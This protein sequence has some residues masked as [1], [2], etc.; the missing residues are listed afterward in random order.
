MKEAI[1]LIQTTVIDSVATIAAN[2]GIQYDSKQMADKLIATAREWYPKIL[3]ESKKDAE[4]ADLFGNLNR[5]KID[6]LVN[7]AFNVA[8]KHGCVQYA[9][10]L[11][12]I[13]DTA[14]VS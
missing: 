5:G 3:D 6:P 11:L 1:N 13:E 14:P 12:G 4:Q 10:F 9:K 8:L 2:K 7:A